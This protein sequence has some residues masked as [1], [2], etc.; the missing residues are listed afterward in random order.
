MSVTND[1]IIPFII[2]SKMQRK[3]NSLWNCTTTI[4]KFT[5]N[6]NKHGNSHTKPKWT[7]VKLSTKRN[8]QRTAQYMTNNNATTRRM[9]VRKTTSGKRE[10]REAT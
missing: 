3:H 2:Y 10:K 1:K 8:H 4:Y 7:N 9:N 5:P 6:A